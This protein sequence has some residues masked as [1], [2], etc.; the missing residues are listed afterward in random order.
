MAK[1]PKKSRKR[2]VTI[3]FRQGYT[4]A[5][6]PEGVEPIPPKSAAADVPRPVRPDLSPQSSA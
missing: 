3:P 6:W 5:P 1:R 2:R 4:G